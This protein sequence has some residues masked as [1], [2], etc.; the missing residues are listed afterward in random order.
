MESI[1]T[2]SKNNLIKPENIHMT[3]NEYIEFIRK[4]HK[5]I[6]NTKSYDMNYQNILKIPINENIKEENDIKSNSKEK[7]TSILNQIKKNINNQIKKVHKKT[8]SLTIQLDQKNKKKSIIKSF[9]KKKQ[10]KI[11]YKNNRNNPLYE[12]IY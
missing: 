11:I 7:S 10:A 12:N 5:K 4:Q 9:P 6:I 2:E 8:N 3:R 1:N